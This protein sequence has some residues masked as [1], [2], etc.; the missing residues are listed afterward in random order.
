MKKEFK[1]W[2]VRFLAVVLAVLFVLAL[3]IQPLLSA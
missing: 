3:F 1:I 2:F